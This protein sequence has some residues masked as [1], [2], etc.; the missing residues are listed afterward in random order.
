MKNTEIAG[1]F[2]NIADLLDI[3]GE[4]P[5][6][7]RAYRKAA[8]NITGLGKDVSSI[9]AA[10]LLEIPGVGHDLAAK[11]EEYLKTGKV[12]AYE[13]L[14]LEA[15]ETLIDMLAIPGLGP[16]TVSLLYRE[17][18]IRDIDNLEK[19]AREHRLS[20]LP[21]IKDKTEEGIIKGIE[22][23]RRFAARHPLGKVLPL[24]NGIRE[25][26]YTSAS[27][28]K[29][30]IAGSLRRWKETIRDIDIIATSK[31][32]DAVMKVFTRMPYVSRIITKGPTKSSVVLKDGIQVDIR[33]VEEE[34]FGSALGY[35]TGSKA[36]NIRLRELASK[37][38]LK[39]NEY[40][41]FR[42]KDN[43]K[44]G[45]KSEEDIYNV[46]GLQYVPPELREDTGE[47]E[48]AAAGTLPD[49]IVAAD[50][51]G[52]L[53][54][55]SNWS[56]GAQDLEDLV[57]TSLAKGYRYIA[58]TD[59][60]KGLGVARGLTE[61]RII[62]QKKMIDAINKKTNRFRLLSGAEVN[63]KSDGSL[64]FDD[65]LLKELDVVIASVHT[66]FKQSA[67][68]ITKRLVTAMKNPFVSIIGHPSGRLIGEREAYEV[69]MEK[70]LKTAAETGTAIEINAY[71]LRLDLTE[72]NVRM[73]RSMNVQL[74]IS[75]DSH[76]SGQ[77]DNMLYGVSVA[78]RGWLE[79]KSVL[80]TLQ[81]SRLL[82]KLREKMVRPAR[83]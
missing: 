49:L 4:N 50:I 61:E 6:R 71:P 47:V 73:A 18:N 54:V 21:G 19:L 62:E 56:D 53:H 69:D 76:N 29:L 41:I 46:L 1:I 25:H 30:V 17:H 44:L 68:Q 72:S 42:E 33:V 67:E 24:A 3:K 11:I 39:I 64:D 15:P 57:E 37:A 66:G 82:K 78:R 27:V 9:S 34:S 8:F 7:I 81:Y 74:V 10:E 26:I 45:G 2:N 65:E 79:K 70:V 75:T 77:F 40:G 16:K 51:K 13:K 28:E 12:D 23:V 36:H 31:D 58:V 20:G 43:H 63:I 32:P 83:Q 60:S 5:F 35:F 48:A 22:M 52:D 38:G 80:N 59:H 55:H 14:K